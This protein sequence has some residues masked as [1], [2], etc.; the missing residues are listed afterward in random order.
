MPAKLLIDGLSLLGQVSGVGRYCHE[1]ASR[2]P[3]DQFERYFYYGYVTRKQ[4]VPRADSAL[5]RVKSAAG[6]FR[7]VKS[8]ARRYLAWSSRRG[9]WDLH[10]Q[11]NFIPLGSIRAKHVV[12]TVHDFSWELH[13]HFHPEERTAYFRKHFYPGVE[14][15]DRIITVSHFVKAEMLQRLPHLADRIEVIHNGFDSS[16]YFPAQTP[17]PAGKYL[18][19]V[20]SIEPRKN[21][22][23]LL[24]AY[25]LVDPA[26]RRQYPLLLVGASG[27]K[28]DEIFARVAELEGTVRY[29]GYVSNEAL[30]E[31]YRGALCFIYPSFYEGFGLPP[32]EAMACGT[33]VIA[34]NVSSLPEVCGDAAYYV[35]PASVE[36]IRDAIQ[37]IVYNDELRES[38]ARLGLARAAAFSWDRSAA[39]HVALFRDVLGG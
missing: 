37:A 17:R 8:L 13:P 24:K 1:V 28:N 19:S 26:I 18:L 34:S 33:P 31:Y 12:A 11:P 14:S 30:A 39:A 36:E 2:I 3:E 35:D 9:S 29:L 38:H 25:A 10:W 27:W 22:G 16:L 21:I 5:S 6:C 7:P 20:G 15:C 23:N 4:H 32:L